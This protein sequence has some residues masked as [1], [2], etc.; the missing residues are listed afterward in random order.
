MGTE[1]TDLFITLHPRKQWKRAS[2]QEELTTL[3]QEELRDL[4]GPR[5]AMSQPIEMR[6]NEMISGVRS[7]VAAILYGDDLDLMVAKASEVERA[8]NSIRGAAEVKVEQVS[9]QPVLQI[10]VKQDEIARYGVTASTVMN[11][12]RALGTHNV[13][14]VYEGQ[15]R[16]PLIIRLPEKARADPEAISQILVATPSGERIPLSR[17]ATIEKVQGPNTIKRDWYQRRIT[18]E[19]NVR[20][21]DLGSFVAEAQ[22]VISQRVQLPAGRYRI[23]WG[24]QFENLQRAQTRLM[25]VVP[26]ALLM[27]LS[28]LY[29][30][31]RNW[32]DSLRVFTGVPFAWI[33]GIL[34]LWV[35][36]MPFSFSTTCCWSLRFGSCAAKE[37][38]LMTLLKRQQ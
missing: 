27:I 25:I 1:L 37:N 3:V 21:R 19:A 12:V 33:G 24:G 16:F 32:V 31:Y 8:L 22:Q 13:G 6:M 35:R 29:M 38:H 15:L 4:P 11:I 17:L 7:D 2:T 26:I 36:D 5:L 14:E 10:R 18:I 30:T 34:A 20:G 23:E 28:L 9:G